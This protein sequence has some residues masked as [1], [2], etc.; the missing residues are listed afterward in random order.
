M[1]VKDEVERERET[2]LLLLLVDA[3]Y[4]FLFENI[5][6]SIA[7]SFI[8]VYGVEYIYLGLYCCI[9]VAMPIAQPPQ[10]NHQHP[11]SI[12]RLL[13]MSFLSY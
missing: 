10:H 4:D 1:I 2:D 11:Y 13:P 12:L 9:S 8:L 5:L 7:L 6:F 3:S